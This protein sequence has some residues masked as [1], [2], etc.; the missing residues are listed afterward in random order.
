MKLFSALVVLSLLVAPAALAAEASR[1]EVTRLAEDAAFD[2]DALAQLRDI[3]SIDGEPVDVERLISGAERTDIERRITTLFSEDVPEPRDPAADRA[4]AESVLG[5]DRYQPEEIPRPFRGPLEWIADRL[6]PV[7]DAIGSFFGWIVDV[8]TTVAAGTPGGA[9]TLWMIIG[10][11][12]VTFVFVQTRR[13]VERRGRAKA[14]EGP[15]GELTRSDDP[16]DL[17]RQA[18]AARDRGDHALEVRLLFRAGV[19][20]L[21]RARAIPARYSLTTGEIKR[22]LH[23]GDFDRVGRS[24]DEIAYGNRSATT[25][26]GDAARAGWARVLDEVKR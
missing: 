16:R 20:R 15:V 2:D 8:F 11:A 9:A 7:G 1:D 10:L 23:S 26:D 25:E 19:I 17:E 21:A 4:D 13:V 14:S 24:F 22:L 12:V 3:D 18:A 6:E 5:Q